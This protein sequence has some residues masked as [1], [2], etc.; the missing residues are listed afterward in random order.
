MPDE[1]DQLLDEAIKS[2]SAVEPS[3]DLAARIL[4]QSQL[5]MA[6]SRRG[7]KLAMAFALPVAAAVVL[8][9]LLL[10]HWAL[11]QPPPTIASAPSTPKLCNRRKRWLL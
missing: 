10:G 7:W 9:F 2:Y 4:H 3:A 6:P 8:A 1:L 11:P 5:Q